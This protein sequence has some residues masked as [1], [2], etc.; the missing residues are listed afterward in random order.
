MDFLLHKNFYSIKKK[1]KKKK[2]KKNWLIRIKAFLVPHWAIFTPFPCSYSSSF[3]LLSFFFFHL[4]SFFS[5]NAY[6]P[7]PFDFFPAPTLYT[8][9]LSMTGGSRNIDV[10]SGEAK[11]WAVRLHGGTWR[12]WVVSFSAIFQPTPVASPANLNSFGILMRF[13]ARWHQV[14]QVLSHKKLAH[15]PMQPRFQTLI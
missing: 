13:W 2:K 15:F 9:H 7:L 8:H 6:C 5:S 12:W 4:P 1:K 3:L 10:G 14:C 11:Q